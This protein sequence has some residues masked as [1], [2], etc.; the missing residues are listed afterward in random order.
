MDSNLQL[1][2]DDVSSNLYPALLQVF[3]IILLG[4]FA[5]TLKIVNKEQGIGLNVF[6]GTFILPVVLLKVNF[7]YLIFSF[8]QRILFILLLKNIWTLDFST[9]DWY[10]LGAI[11]V[12]KAVVFTAAILLSLIIIRPVNLGQAAIFAIYVSQ[13]ND[14]ALGQ[15]IV[16]AIYQ[17]NHP[18]YIRYIF[19]IAP[20]SLLVLNPIGFFLLELNEQWSSVKVEKDEEQEKKTANKCKHDFK[21][22]S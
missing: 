11:F 10:F 2:T 6:V 5:G 17:K 21:K 18:E 22:V 13:S 8:I 7:L 1:N 12:S 19:L 3:T 20:I 9:V 4:Y 16:Q 15:P 14:F